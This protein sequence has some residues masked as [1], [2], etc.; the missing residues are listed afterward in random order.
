MRKNFIFSGLFIFALLAFIGSFLLSVDAIVLASEPDKILHCDFSSSVSCSTVSQS[1]QAQVFGF[2]NAFLGMMFEPVMIFLSVIYLAG[3]KIKNWILSIV[4]LLLFVSLA[5]ALWLFIQSAFV[6][7]V[8]CPWCLVVCVST[9]VMT[10]LFLRFNIKNG[11]F[12]GRIWSTLSEVYF[13]YAL[14]FLFV[15][16]VLGTI[17]VKYVL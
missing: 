15:S 4:Q 3:S 13:E 1:W 14:I 16:F 5:F 17:L 9:I 6:I 2:P 10:F 12:K 8:L 7:N 11:T